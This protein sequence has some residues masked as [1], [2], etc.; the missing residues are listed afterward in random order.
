MTATRKRYD[1]KYKVTRIFLADYL[2]LKELAQKA[3]VS[4]AEALNQL[5]TDR[6]K[7]EVLD[8]AKREDLDRAKREVP[9]APR[10][11]IPIFLKRATSALS[12]NG[13]KHI[14]FVIRP[15]GGRIQ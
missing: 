9:A 3:G 10:T 11:Q 12:I 8:R 13:D 2:L 4:M 6:A 5:V 15:K 1:S 14:A 7:R